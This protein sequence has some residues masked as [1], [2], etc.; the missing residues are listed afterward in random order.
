LLSWR[1]L[2]ARQWGDVRQLGGPTWFVQG[3]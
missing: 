2:F 1:A 3:C